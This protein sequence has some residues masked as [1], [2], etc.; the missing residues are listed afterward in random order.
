MLCGYVVRARGPAQH[1]NLCQKCYLAQEKK[2][3]ARTW[4]DVLGVK[5]APL[6]AGRVYSRSTVYIGNINYKITNDELW[7]W[8]AAW[9]DIKKDILVKRCQYIRR[10]HHVFGKVFKTSA[11]IEFE[12]VEHAASFYEWINGAGHS[13]R[14]F[15]AYPAVEPRQNLPLPVTESDDADNEDHY[16]SK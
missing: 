12:A 9:W 2:A 11:F 14:I 13:G 7:E 6:E 3:I 5:L 16:D 10:G 4:S 1:F 8:L 15:V